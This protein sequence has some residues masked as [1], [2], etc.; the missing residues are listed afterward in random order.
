M[1]RTL[2]TVALALL[3]I[4]CAAEQRPLRFSIT[5]SGV[6]PLVEIRDGEAVG[7]ILHDLP[8]RLADKLGRRAELLVMPR[9]R[10]HRALLNNEIDVRCY[11]NPAWLSDT[12]PGYL[13][14]VPFMVQ[15]DL[16][17]SRSPE[18]VTPETLPRQSIGTVLGFHYPTLY[19]RL[20]A[21]TL[22]RNDARTQ[23]L[24][25]NKLAAG[26]YDYAISNELALH[27][28]NRHRDAASRLHDVHEL[29]SDPAACLVRNAPDVPTEALLR[30]L[31]EM[32]RDGEF[33]AILQRYR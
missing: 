32:Q 23:G 27:W 10:V 18:P 6:M 5:E 14:S 13:W 24:V 25:L 31:L 20:V 3:S 11:V 28:H 22:R 19:P 16:L 1:P 4:C 8:M 9:L 33:E 21:G 30:A 12:Y 29:S 2:T 15:R 26:R 17:V 7:G